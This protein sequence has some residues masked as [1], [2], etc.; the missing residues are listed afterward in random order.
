VD[1][2]LHPCL[3]DSPGHE[4]WVRDIKGSGGVFSI[5]LKPGMEAGLEPAL[6]ALKVFSIGA[7]WGGTHS[8]VAP[9]AIAA[10]RTACPWT[11]PGTVLRLSI[12][13]EQPDELWHDLETMLASLAQAARAPAA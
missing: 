8:L 5:V 11:H 2:V 6:T 3:P 1:R 7:S 13:L 10:D 12:G 9:M 4:F